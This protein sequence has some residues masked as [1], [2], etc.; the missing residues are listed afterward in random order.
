MLT[1]YIL[2]I[3]SCF[4][5][6]KCYIIIAWVELSENIN[7]Q[8]KRNRLMTIRRSSFFLG[9]TGHRL[10]PYSYRFFTPT[11]PKLIFSGMFVAS[12]FAH[13]RKFSNLNKHAFC[14]KIDERNVVSLPADQEHVTNASSSLE[15]EFSELATQPVNIHG[16]IP[17][18][19]HYL[20]PNEYDVKKIQRHFNPQNGGVHVCTGTERLFSNA[21]MT[22][23]RD[24]FIGIDLDP[25]VIAYNNFNTLLLKISKN[26]VDY[27]SLAK[28]ILFSKQGEGDSLDLFHILTKEFETYLGPLITRYESLEDRLKLIQNRIN[29]SDL[30][31]RWKG[32]YLHHLKDFAD[33]YYPAKKRFYSD[34]ES[35]A[36]GEYHNDNAI[37]KKVQKC[38]REGRFIFLLRGINDLQFLQQSRVAEIDVSNI[39]D[40]FLV[41]PQFKGP[42]TASTIIIWTVVGIGEDRYRSWKYDPLPQDKRKELEDL[43]SSI[44]S[45]KYTHLDSRN[46]ALLG[47]RVD[48]VTK[49]RTWLDLCRYTDR[50]TP[51]GIPLCSYTNETLGTLKK[52]DIPKGVIKSFRPF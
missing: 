16:K 28:P 52:C 51:E 47:D 22:P 13:Y 29:K 18:D 11:L 36:Y 24:G 23:E 32:Y 26:R 6:L 35:K 17:L 49:I 46:I 19:E 38:A 42:E 45:T 25:Q 50:Y 1:A 10:T 4:V 33:I 9:G 37:F 27:L 2:D 44:S 31:P 40:Y 20:I 30:S 12:S 7:Q 48:L 21:G 43:V 15:E 3:V 34:P 39:P 41:G 14:Q 5:C 8:H